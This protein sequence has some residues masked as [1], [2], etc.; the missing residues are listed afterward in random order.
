[1]FDIQLNRR[2]KEL[3]IFSGKNQNQFAMHIKV[4]AQTVGDIVNE[5]KK[6]GRIVLNQILKY[7]PEISEEWLISGI[8]K[9]T[10]KDY[11]NKRNK[12]KPY[13]YDCLNC[14]MLKW[15]MS[16]MEKDI[17]ELRKENKKLTEENAVLRYLVDGGKKNTG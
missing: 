8:G 10:D 9:M 4:A 7:F 5:R 15:K 12:S 1:M 16:D 11:T 6:A 17:T 13:D 2:I 3:M 14:E